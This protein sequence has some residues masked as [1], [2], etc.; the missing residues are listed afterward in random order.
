MLPAAFKQYLKLRK[1]QWWPREDLLDLQWRRAAAIIAHAY[2]HVPFYRAKFDEAG[3]TPGD[4]RGPDD[5]PLIPPCTKEELRQAYGT[6]GLADNFELSDCVEAVTSGSTG[7]PL[8]FRIDNRSLAFRFAMNLRTLEFSHYRLGQK[9]FQVSPPLSGKLGSS[10]KSRLID[11]LLR[12]VTVPPFERDLGAKLKQLIAF[13]P[14]AIVGYTS[15]IKSLADLAPGAPLSYPIRS[16]MTT[17]EKLL[18]ATRATLSAVF[19]GQVFDQYG[20][21]ESGRSA[22]ECVAGSGYHVNVEGTLIEIVDEAGRPVEAGDTGEVLVTNLINYASPFIRYKI[23][24]RAA[25]S[26]DTKCGCGR[27]LPMLD[28]VEGRLNDIIILPDG[29]KVMPEY[30]YLTLREIGGLAQ[31]QIRQETPADLKVL[32]TRERNFDE[33]KRRQVELEYQRYLSDIRVTWEQVEQIDKIAGKHRHI[34]SATKS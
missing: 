12:R 32:Y 28:R 24:D 23:G 20:S 33:V 17:S 26:P 10:S 21:V 3:V 22:T 31:F 18:P 6:G 11:T 4:I 9:L 5:L 34:V 19:G 30:F 1:S 2:E 29:R 13:R 16:I 27:A 14:D 25:Y 15:Y 7:A 8:K